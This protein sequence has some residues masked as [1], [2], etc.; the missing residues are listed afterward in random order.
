MK[1]IDFKKELKHLYKPTVKKFATVEVPDTN[2][3]M[4][5]GIGNPNTE[6]SYAEAVQVIFGLSYT[7][8]FMV[9]KGDLQ[10]DYGVLPLEGL[11]WMDD[12]SRFSVDTKDEWKWT[13]MIMQPEFITRDIYDHAI[14][15]LIRKKN[16]SNIA[17]VRFEPYSEGLSAQIMYIGPYADEEP[18]IKKLHEY[19]HD[20]GF[21]RYGKHHEI[22]LSDPRRSKPEKLK[23]VLRQPMRK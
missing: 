19:I 23:T 14:K 16:P 21:N 17:Q 13:M 3:I 9:K 11:W 22:Y 5:D 8:K 6:K 20:E 18:A 10:I 1:K 12:M 4:I 7:I 2:F 15:E